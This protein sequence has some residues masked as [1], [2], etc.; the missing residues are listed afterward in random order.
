MTQKSQTRSRTREHL[1]SFIRYKPEGMS[2]REFEEHYRSARPV[3]EAL[4]NLL[5]DKIVSKEKVFEHDYECPSWS[6]KQAHINGYNECARK[7]LDLLPKTNE[8]T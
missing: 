4:A 6:H 3:L 8:E 7:T 1:S 5:N 2:D